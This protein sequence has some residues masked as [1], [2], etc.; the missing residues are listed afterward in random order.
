[1]PDFQE[2]PHVDFS[3]IQL[4]L[5]VIKTKRG[6]LPVAPQAPPMTSDSAPETRPRRITVRTV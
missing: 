4:L 1:M 3:F 6:L 5:S 2:V